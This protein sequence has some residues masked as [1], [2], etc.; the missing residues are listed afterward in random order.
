MTTTTFD[1]HARNYD[2]VALSRLGREHRNRVHR[3]VE[4]LI[5]GRTQVLDLGCGTGLDSAWLAPRV[6][7]VHAVDPS[8][9][10]VAIATAR[11]GD[12]NVTLQVG[13]SG[14]V[15]G[16]E[17]FDV[18]LANF[19]AVNC[20][21]SFEEFGADL[22]RLLQPEGHAVLV[23]MPAVSPV[24]RL[25][26]LS[27]RNRSLWNRRTNGPA[28]AAGYQGLELTYADGSQLAKSM[29]Q[30]ELVH[31]E[32]LGLVLPGFEYRHAL[33]HRTRLT[34]VLAAIDRRVGRVGA[35]L[36]WGD[37]IITVFRKPS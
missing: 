32:A 21:E 24:E 10:M 17:R 5:D 14:A 29:P 18:V 16:H 35:W 36:G 7:S 37:H 26:A 25:V 11:L 3:V 27:R 30:L 20:V 15:S 4:P 22:V 23:T 2:A 1:S 34:R 28:T 13:T 19:G 6:E 9:E 33:E 8:T 12:A 31:A